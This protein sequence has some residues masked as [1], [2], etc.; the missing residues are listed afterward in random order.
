MTGG[1]VRFVRRVDHVRDTGNDQPE[2]LQRL[3]NRAFTV[4]S[5][6]DQDDRV[7]RRPPVR[8]H[9]QDP[10]DEPTLP[11]EQVEPE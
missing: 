6:D 1:R 7:A 9:G 8:V 2:Q 11:V 10:A 4:L 3:Q 5:R